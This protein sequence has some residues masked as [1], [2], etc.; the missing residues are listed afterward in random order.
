MTEHD[1]IE[2]T[3]P[4]GDVLVHD[5]TRIRPEVDEAFRKVREDL[6]RGAEETYREL[7]EAAAA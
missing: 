5:A 1:K 4:N 3:L 6:A 7:R 2:H